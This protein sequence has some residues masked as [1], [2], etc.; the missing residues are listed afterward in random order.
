MD[1]TLKILIV[2]DEM[3]SRE[4]LRSKLQRFGYLD[5]QEAANGEDALALLHAR[6][7]DLVIADIMMA[8]MDGLELLKAI[9]QENTEI[10]CVLISGYEIFNYAREA[11][12]YHVFYYL[13]KPTEDEELFSVLQAAEQSVQKRRGIAKLQSEFYTQLHSSQNVL[14]QQYLEK[15]I[16]QPSAAHNARDC[17]LAPQFI[18]DSFAVVLCRLADLSEPN[19]FG[20]SSM[21]Y[22]CIENIMQELLCAHGLT[23][24]GFPVQQ[25]LCLLC[26]L[27]QAFLPYD[28]HRQALENIFDHAAQVCRQTLDVSMQFGVGLAQECSNL[29]AAFYAA[30]KILEVRQ[31]SPQKRHDSAER[32]HSLTQEQTQNLFRALDMQDPQ[33]ISAVLRDIYSPFLHQ[34]QRQAGMCNTLNL[35]L[36]MLLFKYL[37][38]NNLDGASILGD[39]FDLYQ[40]ANAQRSMEC[41]L[42]WMQQQALACMQANAQALPQ[43]TDSHGFR[44]QVQP[45]LEEHFAEPLTLA[46]VAAQFHFSPSHFSRLFKKEFG[47]TFIKFLLNYRLHE[48]QRLLASTDIRVSE[49]GKRVGFQDPKHFYKVFKASAGCQPSVYR[50]RF[51]K[52]A[53]T[54]GSA[55]APM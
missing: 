28:V 53:D 36:I 21:L 49:V 10:L 34:L 2:D 44:P 7:P 33:A 51:Q 24:N 5:I 50:E 54:H 52:A 31:S 45:Y 47:V 55:K 3:L 26:S 14:R 25:D 41:L 11:M 48:A 37:R 27:P 46:A 35:Q 15:L 30:R 9:R 38:Q 23:C 13:L 43:Q 4:L 32:S 17:T 22:F 39:E 42:P 40:Q 6:T 1:A 19:A 20:D 16:F 18:S 29:S 12:K 8:Q